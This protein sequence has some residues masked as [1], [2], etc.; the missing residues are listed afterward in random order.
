M[1]KPFLGRIHLRNAFW[2]GIF[3]KVVWEYLFDKTVFGR[4]HCINVF[5]EGIFGK[6]VWEDLFDETIFGLLLYFFASKR[7][8][9]SGLAAVAAENGPQPHNPYRW[10][11]NGAHRCL[12]RKTATQQQGPLPKEL[13]RPLRTPINVKN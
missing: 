1:T 6:V 5:W 13:A 3:D 2:E 12:G 8:R 10:R 4:I 7:G 9:H 11:S